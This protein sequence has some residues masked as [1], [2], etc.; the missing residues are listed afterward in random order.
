MKNY[1]I[2]ADATCDLSEE[3]QKQYDIKIIGGHI[4]LP[5]KTEI[6]SFLKWDR[7]S[8]DEFYAEL[9]KD[10][11][12]F[13]TS[14]ASIGEFTLAFSEYAAAGY[15]I[16]AISISGGI[17]GAHGFMLQAADAVMKKYPGTQ[18]CCVDSRRFG[19]GFG[20]LAVHASLLRAQGKSI[21]EVT[22]Y[23]ESNKNRFHQAGWLDD[24]TFVAKKGRITH[25]KAFF[26]TL[27]GVKPIGE[28]DSNG[29]TTVL[30]KARGA[31]KAYS[32]LLSYIEQTIEDPEDQIVF[33]A[34]TNRQPQAEEY[35]KMIEERFH[36][37]EVRIND[38]FPLCGINIGPGLMAAYYVGKPISDGLTFERGLIEKLL[39]GEEK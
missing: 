29:L 3:L 15:D 32:V 6:P 27:A 33:I 23:L 34:H 16:L 37:R 10:P 31:K 39:N 12:G 11:T 9:K 13:S 5:D 30:G 2:V 19:P 1:V 20:L 28:F 17:S 22:D 21:Q 25:P 4:M 35:K 8:R 24:L 26:G 14:P 7:Y 38:V 18:I 36:P